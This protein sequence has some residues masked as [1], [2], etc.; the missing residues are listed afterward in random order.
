MNE[1]DERIGEVREIKEIRDN[2]HELTDDSEILKDLLTI[3]KD[4]DNIHD[5]Y[6]ICNICK[7]DMKD[8]DCVIYTDIKFPIKICEYQENS[9]SICPSC[10][11]NDDT[12]YKISAIKKSKTNVKF[13]RENSVDNVNSV[14]KS[15]IFGCII[16]FTL[17]FYFGRK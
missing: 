14:D 11:I 10:Q 1:N 12:E 9:I 4:K 17:G 15:M 2:Y 5:I 6:D 8:K 7:K 3:N 16:M 13:I